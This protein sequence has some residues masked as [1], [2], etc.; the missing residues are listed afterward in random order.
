MFVALSDIIP[1][2]QRPKTSMSDFSGI[3]SNSWPWIEIL[4]TE[5]IWKQ[6]EILDSTVYILNARSVCRYCSFPSFIHCRLQLLPIEI[7][8]PRNMPISMHIIVIYLS[9]CTYWYSLVWRLLL[10]GWTALARSLICLTYSN[11]L[12]FEAVSSWGFIE[13]WEPG[14]RRFEDKMARRKWWDH[15]GHKNNVVQCRN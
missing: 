12:G 11:N 3:A 2:T 1:D 5:M 4:R 8:T 15:I 14:G 9:F 7:P 13:D 10:G 6:C